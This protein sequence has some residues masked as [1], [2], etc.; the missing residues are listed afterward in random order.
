MYVVAFQEN[1]PLFYLEIKS[2]PFNFPMRLVGTVGLTRE[3]AD[4]VEFKVEVRSFRHLLFMLE[5]DPA[6]DSWVLTTDRQLLGWIETL[7]PLDVNSADELDYLGLSRVTRISR[8]P[9]DP[10]GPKGP[11]DPK[12]PMADDRK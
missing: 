5:N 3:F 10:K 9:M 4:V 7:S 11:N 12:A 6:I 8:K 2:F 1:E